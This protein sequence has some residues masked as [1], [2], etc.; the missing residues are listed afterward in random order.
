MADQ[1]RACDRRSWLRGEQAEGCDELYEVA[2]QHTDAVDAF[3]QAMEV[4]A[5]RV[6][7][8][9][10]LVVKVEAGE[11]APTRVVAQ[12]DQAGA[13]LGAKQHPAQ[14]QDWNWRRFDGGRAQET[15]EEA[16]LE[17]HRFPAEP[18][19]RLPDVHDR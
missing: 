2:K 8:R 18:V 10:G 17:E 1:K 7:Q 11:V 4:P 6:R 5:E 9:L 3:R 14:R 13:Q 16:R 15:R 12:F 19:K